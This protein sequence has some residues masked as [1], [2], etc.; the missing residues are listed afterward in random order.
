MASGH[1]N[2]ANRPNTWLHRPSCKR[3]ENPCQPGAVHTCQPGAVHTW[4]IPV[5]SA[6]AWNGSLGRTAEVGRGLTAAELVGAPSA[7]QLIV[8][9]PIW[10]RFVNF[11]H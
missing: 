10:R 8:M 6:A 9:G 11:S 7:R 2:R 1:V 3:E 5:L 4:H